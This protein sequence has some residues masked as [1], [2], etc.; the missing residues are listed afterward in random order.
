VVKKHENIKEAAMEH[1]FSIARST[2]ED[3][4]R[5]EGFKL[6]PDFDPVPLKGR[7]SSLRR[8]HR[9][10][11]ISFDYN[12]LN[13]S[14][15]E[16]EVYVV[17]AEFENKSAVAD[18]RN[19]LPDDVIGVFADLKIEPFSAPG[20]EIPTIPYGDS[21][22]V[23][24]KLGIRETNLTGK[25]VRIAIV[26]SGIHNEGNII[27][28]KGWAPPGVS[29]KPGQAPRA[30][31][32]MCAFDALICAPDADLLD[33]SLLLGFTGW[34]GSFLRH[35][36]AA[37]ADLLDLITNEPGPLIVNNSWGIYD[38]NDDYPPGDP[39]NYSTNINHP[40]C[41]IVSSLI[42]AGADILF[43]AGNCGQNC[44]DD[45]CKDFFG[46]GHSIHG[47]NSHPDVITV[48]GVTTHDM[49]IGYSSQGPGGI[50]NSKPDVAAYSH[51]TGSGVYVS[52]NGVTIDSGTSAAC[53]VAA[54]VIGAVRE[55]VSNSN[56]TPYTLKAILQRTAIDVNGNG[57]DYDI[58]YGIINP[59][60]ILNAISQ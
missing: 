30:H 3:I 38:L 31:G 26:D 1:R 48:A 36:I 18:F 27:S 44:P 59:K 7:S 14:E 45:R 6:N 33:Y 54:G 12:N 16:A 11:G 60:G 35:A 21:S 55:R 10:S 25:N 42:A 20:C 5:P 24:E 52:P 43:A 41:E 50:S 22:K 4:I 56:V 23:A 28:S 39:S 57:W 53:P 2:L 49:H 32:T 9:T 13:K 8:L 40:F 15:G 37:Y 29:F 58:G 46:P 17:S 47:A 34:R 19:K 51:F